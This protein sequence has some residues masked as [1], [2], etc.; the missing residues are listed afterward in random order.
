MR[1]SAIAVAAVLLASS[2]ASGQMPVT[3]HTQTA[4]EQIP[5]VAAILVDSAFVGIAVSSDQRTKALEIVKNS[6]LDGHTVRMPPGPLDRL[7]LIMNRTAD[8]R[9]LLTTDSDRAKFDKNVRRDG[10]RAPGS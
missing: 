10:Q 6:L 5:A 3:Y 4:L 7:A 2:V 9:A 1:P 8:L